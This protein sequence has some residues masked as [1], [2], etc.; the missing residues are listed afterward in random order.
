MNRLPQDRYASNKDQ[1]LRTAKH[2]AEFIC[3]NLTHLEKFD[4]SGRKRRAAITF[5]DMLC[6]GEDLTPG[7]HSYLESIWETTMKGAGYESCDVHH[8]TKGRSLKFG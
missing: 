2:L 7:Q 1:A 4:R 8:D 5:R 6:A 3:E